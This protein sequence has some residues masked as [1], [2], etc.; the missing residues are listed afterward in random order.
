MPL[1]ILNLP[2]QDKLKSLLDYNKE[3]GVLRWR[4]RVNGRV[5]AGSEICSTQMKISRVLYTTSRVIWKLVTGNDPPAL[6]DHQNG[7]PLDNRWDNLRLATHS[8]NCINSVR[9]NKTGYKGVSET[10]YGKFQAWLQ[11]DKRT[12]VSLGNFNTAEEAHQ[13]RL[14]AIES[15]D[16]YR[17]FAVDQLRR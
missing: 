8:Q 12:R 11:I 15:C 5:P 13:A 10:P 3:T 1:P 2:P 9:L 17:E 14:A 16:F 4:I 6:V 7:N